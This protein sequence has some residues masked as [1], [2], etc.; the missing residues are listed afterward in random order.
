MYHLLLVVCSNNVSTLHHMTVLQYLKKYI[1]CS[2]YEAHTLHHMTV[3]QYLKKYIA[4]S[5]YEAHV[6]SNF[7]CLIETGGLIEVTGS[8]VH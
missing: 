4:C 1:A 3:L 7:N 5:K 6:A 8:H 2:K